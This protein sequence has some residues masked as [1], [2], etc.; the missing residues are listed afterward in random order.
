MDIVML[1]FILVQQSVILD[2]LWA[3]EMAAEV[4]Y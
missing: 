3:T 4:A 1:I 2:E